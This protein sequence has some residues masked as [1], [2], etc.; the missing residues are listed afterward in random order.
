VTERFG[1]KK[2]QEISM[3][4]NLIAIALVLGT[5]GAAS[6]A[7][8]KTQ[9]LSNGGQAYGYVTGGQ[10]SGGT[11]INGNFIPRG[12]SPAQVPAFHEEDNYGSNANDK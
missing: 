9:H 5:L 8:A 12:T 7:Q 3:K 11:F 1:Q 4:R 2:R 6:I 10:T